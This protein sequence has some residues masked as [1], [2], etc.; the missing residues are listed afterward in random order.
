M[1]ISNVSVSLCGNDILDL[2]QYATGN[3]KNGTIVIDNA[4]LDDERINVFGTY[5][6]KILFIK[7]KVSFKIALSNFFTTYN[8]IVSTVTF[9]EPTTLQKSKM[10]QKKILR[11]L[12]AVVAKHTFLQLNEEV[13][14]IDV[15]DILKGFTPLS[16]NVEKVTFAEDKITVDFSNSYLNLD[17]LFPKNREVEKE[18]K[19]IVLYD[20]EN[21][22]E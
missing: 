9:L 8:N 20:S 1:N 7:K 3:R 18:D 2:L 11:K 17:M 21:E 5:T 14:V 6:M 22:N 10:I 4:T 19:E 16:I 12:K 15:G 13:F